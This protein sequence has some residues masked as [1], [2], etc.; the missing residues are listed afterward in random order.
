MMDEAKFQRQS[1][2]GITTSS[3]LEL[4]KFWESTFSQLLTC[5]GFF[6]KHPTWA[7]ITPPGLRIHYGRSKIP[8][9]IKAWYYYFVQFRVAKVI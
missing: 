6:D 5:L 2:L 8:T 4:P 9:T 7:V 1:K 3:N